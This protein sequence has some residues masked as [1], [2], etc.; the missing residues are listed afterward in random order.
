MKAPHEVTPRCPSCGKEMSL[1]AEVL[2][3]WDGQPFV[4][5]RRSC[6]CRKYLTTIQAARS[7]EVCIDSLPNVTGYRGIASVYQANTLLGAGQ[8]QSL[9]GAGERSDPKPGPRSRPDE[10]VDSGANG[11]AAAPAKES[12]EDHAERN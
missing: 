11:E 7:S 9:A 3:C 4:V 12:E 10:I 2:V 6:S 1:E 8:E 5:R